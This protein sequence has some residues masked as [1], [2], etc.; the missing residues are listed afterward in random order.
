MVS[1]ISK[2]EDAINSIPEKK[3]KLRKSLES[4]QSYSSSLASFTLDW[5]DLEDHF[6]SVEKSIDERFKAL[7]EKEK[8]KEIQ[9]QEEEEEEEE[10]HAA[11]AAAEGEPA[12]RPDL[13]SLCVNMD[14]KGLRAY[15]SENRRDLV[16]LREELAPAIRCAPDP[17]VLVLD[18]MHGFYPPNSNFKNKNK[19][20]GKGGDNEEDGETQINR[21]ICINLL[22]KLHLVS[23]NISPSVKER[24]RK[25]AFDWKSMIPKFGDNCLESLGF[26]NLIAAYALVSEFP[27]NQVLELFISVSRRKQAVDLLKSLGL[28]DKLPGNS[29]CPAPCFYLLHCIS[30]PEKYCIQ[31]NTKH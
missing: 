23:P 1:S 12:P 30:F 15:I 7:K 19:R 10:P 29:P 14:G 31:H 3:E 20:K 16:A 21:R 26:L 24:A 28:V 22:E 11:A 5:K 2:I 17:A 9:N 6:S 4:L 13:R 18:A 8:E 27:T 25:L